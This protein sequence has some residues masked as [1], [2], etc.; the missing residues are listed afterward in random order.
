MLQ[1]AF[2][3]ISFHYVKTLTVSVSLYI[4]GPRPLCQDIHCFYT[5][6]NCSM[7]MGVAVPTSHSR[8]LPLGTKCNQQALVLP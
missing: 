2:A 7:L 4:F 8:H 3:Q 5:I 6:L 1:R